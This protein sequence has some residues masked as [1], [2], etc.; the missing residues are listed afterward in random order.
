MIYRVITL[1]LLWCGA[2]QADDRLAYFPENCSAVLSFDVEQLEK[3]PAFK[4]LG[5]QF[6]QN[7]PM[8]IRV[9]RLLAGI[10]LE[11]A[12]S[13]QQKFK[14]T[15]EF[16]AVATLSEM[17]PI[18]E[19]LAL[20]KMQQPQLKEKKV[21]F[22]G[23]K[24]WL[25]KV[26][27]QPMLAATTYGNDLIF[28]SATLVK[29]AIML[30]SGIG[31]SL[32]K[33]SGF[34]A[35]CQNNKDFLWATALIPQIKETGEFKGVTAVNLNVSYAGGLKM[36]SML[37]C[38]NEDQAG[39]IKEKLE[40]EI[41]K[42][43]DN[44]FIKKSDFKVSASG[45]FLFASML[46]PEARIKEMTDKF[47][48]QFQATAEVAAA[49]GG[50]DPFAA[51]APGGA[52]DP[53]EAPAT[54]AAAVPEETLD[55]LTAKV[56]TEWKYQ[57]EI[58]EGTKADLLIVPEGMTFEEASRQLVW[59]QPRKESGSFD[60]LIRLHKAAGPEFLEMTMKVID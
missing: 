32:L 25:I 36:N 33:N 38:S 8:N 27:E 44:E 15:P 30:K 3:L 52:A 12:I 51:G 26:P 9:T 17:K 6:N 50:A 54:E 58:P 13:D 18:E 45:S 42:I 35:L 41:D 19:L 4:T 55:P 31:K 57:L 29:K 5:G 1:F 49:Q 16:M 11:A 43:P 40:Q 21:V 7:S 20:I 34:M 59:S 22:K 60:L 2:M 10:P 53:G 37:V 39:R 24:A 48:K 14:K 28:G 56:G 23:Q 46:Y 47:T